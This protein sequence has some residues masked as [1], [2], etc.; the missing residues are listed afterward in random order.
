MNRALADWEAEALCQ[1]RR[2]RW[3]SQALAYEF[4]VSLR[5]VYRTLARERRYCAA[6]SCPVV[7]PREFC[8]YHAVS[9]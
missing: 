2:R 9:A 7:T 5:T 3:S 4:G 1:R 8:Y 6:G